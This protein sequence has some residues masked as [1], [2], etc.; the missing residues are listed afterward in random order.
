MLNIFVLLISLFFSGSASAEERVFTRNFETDICTAWL[1]RLGDK[2]W[3]HC[4]VEHDLYLWAGGKR[5]ELKNSNLRLHACVKATGASLMADIMLFGIRIGGLSPFKLESKKFGNA[6][7]ESNTDSILTAYELRQLIKSLTLEQL[8]NYEYLRAPFI[9]NL[10][11][12][13]L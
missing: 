3:S 4:C 6:W 11:K 7:G 10:K 8:T 2:D 5:D 1:N 13:N 12:I 9:E